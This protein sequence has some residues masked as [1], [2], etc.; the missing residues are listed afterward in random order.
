[1]A[2]N[3]RGGKIEAKSQG[4]TIDSNVIKGLEIDKFDLTWAYSP[5]DATPISDRMDKADSRTP[6][7]NGS[8]MRIDEFS[9]Y[10][11]RLIDDYHIVDVVPVDI[12]RAECKDWKVE[13][14]YNRDWFRSDHFKKEHDGL[15][16][17]FSGCSN[18]EGIGADIE[19]TWSHMLYTEISKSVKTSGY[20]NLARAGSGWHR[21]IQNFHAYVNNYS[22]PDYLFILMPNIL[23]NFKWYSG[24]WQYQQ[25]NP[26]A[27]PEKRQEYIDMH[28]KEFPVWALMWNAFLDYCTA[29]GTKVVWTTWDEWELSNIEAIDQFKDTF[30][31][32]D[33]LTESEIAQKYS[34][35]L[36]RKDAAR[37][38]DGHDGYIQQTQWFEGFKEQVKIRGV[39]NETN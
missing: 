15:H 6:V 24:G 10:N 30:F 39:L 2:F 14:K 11:H 28:R 17:V 36:D 26:W 29:V 18:T 19:N 38:R 25:F 33:P 8:H 3:L 35:L 12:I 13:Y 9:K 16:I 23:R 31:T 32:I 34:H 20:F 1:M 22:A 7:E 27:E 5:P 4:W 21:I 37:V